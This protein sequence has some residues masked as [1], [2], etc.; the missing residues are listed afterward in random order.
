MNGTVLSI[1]LLLVVAAIVMSG[2]DGSF[3]GG[4]FSRVRYVLG[5]EIG[6][7]TRSADV[8]DVAEIFSKQVYFQAEKLTF[9]NNMEGPEGSNMP[10]IRKDDLEAGEAGA[11]TINT[12]IYLNLTGA[13][14]TGDTTLLEGNEEKIEQRLMKFTTTRLKHATRVGDL[15][16]LRSATLERS[17]AE[18]LLARWLAGQ[19]D[20]R[21][22]NEFT[23]Q[24]GFTVI[25]TKNKWA[26]GTAATRDQ[27][28]DT[29]AGGRLTWDEISRIKAYAQT[30]LKI[31]P[32]RLE[33][34]K[35]IFGLALHPYA[36][37][38]LKVN[39]AKWA[40]AQREAAE[41]GSGNPLFTGA[42]GMVDGV[43]LYEAQR[44]PRSVNAHAT[45]PTMTADNIFFGAQA[46]SRGYL[47][48][49]SWREQEFS[50]GEEYG[51]AVIVDVGQKLNVF[52][53]NATETAADA[54]DDTA[55]GSMVVY[56]AALAPTQ[57]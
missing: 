30:E 49:P 50:Y 41:S 52:D 51:I 13:G 37:L 23:G 38:S 36:A 16:E 55:I 45:V 2:I 31:E 8:K 22:F 34:G 48:R 5:N 20:N 7:V 3:R 6:A 27:I 1:I 57:P 40:Q 19:L 4:F 10:V 35:E 29:D 11:D 47:R 53:L 32:L 56:T 21:I 9:W 17:K 25:P 28:Q 12:T 39:D 15:A 42:L 33:N 26:A 43:V 46:M 54:T 44:V 14:L 24:A 18:R